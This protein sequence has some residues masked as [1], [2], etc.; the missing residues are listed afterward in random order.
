[1]LKRSLKVLLSFVVAFCTLSITSVK[2]E[3]TSYTIY[4]TPHD[5]SYNG[6]S[7]TLSDEMN[8]V[9]S[10]GIDKYTKSHVDDVLKILNKSGTEGQNVISNKTNVLVGIYGKDDAVNKYFNDNTNVNKDLFNKYDS[11]MLSIRDG[12]I[13]VLG[14]DTDAAFHGVTT[15]K[16]IFNQVKNNEIKELTINDYADVKGRGFIE[17]YYGNPWSNEDR[18]DL[19]TF[20]GD[21]KLNQYIYAPKDDPKHNS[22]WR[23][24]YT[25]K[26]LVEIAKLA[27]AGNKSKCY[28]VYAL[29]TFMHNAVRFDN[30]ENYQKDLQVIK[31]KF[32][33]LMGAGVKQ[34]AI[35]ADDA[36]VPAGGGASYTKLMKDLTDWLI[37]KQKTVEGLKSDTLFCPNDYMG[38]GTSG[39]MQALKDLPDSV[40]IIQTGGKVWGEVGPN[41]NDAFYNNMGRPAY[42]WIN[43]PCSDN[44]KDSL[45]MGGAEAVLKPNVDAHKVDGIV[46]NP[47][48][49]SEASKQGLFTNA[50]YAWNI[51]KDTDHYKTVWDDSFAFMDHGTIDETVASN[52]LR[53]MSKHMMNSKQIGNNESFDLSP[54]LTQFLKDLDAGVDISAQAEDL[55][56]EFQKLYD[57]A[58]NYK[59]NPG[60]ERTRNQ[61]VY[62]LDCWMDT[63]TAVINYLDTALALQNNA[64]NDVIWNYYAAGQTAFE[65]SKTHGFHYVD[66]TEYAVAGRL[67][68]NPFMKSLD[69]NLS[70]KME[71]II[72]PGKQIIKYISNRSDTPEGSTD[73]IFDNKGTTEIV[74]KNPNSIAEGTY[75]GISY[76]KGI[77]VDKVIFRLGANSNPKDTFLKAKV[78]YTHDGKEWKDLDSKIYDLPNEV[79]L[80]NLGLTGVK[81]IRMIATEAK[82]NTWLGVR[83]I[84]V[85]PVDEPIIDEDNGTISTDKISV[86]GGQLGNVNDGDAST[87]THFAES[88]YK[89]SGAPIT[90]YIPVDSKIIL[91]FEQT[92]QLGIISFKQDS[93]TD[94]IKKYAIEYSEDGSDWK[95]LKTYSSGDA[96]ISLDVSS[97]NIVA[98]AIRIR[99]L[100]LNLKNASVGYWWKVYDFSMQKAQNETHSTENVFTNTKF[101]L[102]TKYD[103]ALTILKANQDVTL[104]KNE[105]IGVDLSR[106]KDLKDINID[107][108]AN[109]QLTIQVS[110]NKVDWSTLTTRTLPDA[111]YVRLINLNDSEVTFKLNSFEVA[112]NE[113]VAPYLHETTMGINGSWGVGEDSRNNGAAFDGNVDTTTEFGDLP[114][115][116]QYIIYDLGQERSIK[117]LEMFCQDSAVNY[118]RDA[119]ILVSNDLK[120]WTKV[121]TIGDGIENT[122]DAGVKCIDSDAGYIAS[123]PY[124]NKVSVSGEIEATQARYIK[125]LMTA[126]NNNRAV[127]FNEI[128]INDGEYVPVSNDPTFDSSAIEVQGF[129]PQNMFDG[130]L[131]TSYKANTKD[132]GYIQYT[133]SDNLD[134][135]RINII[136]K[137]NISNAKVMAYVDTE[138]GRNWVQ[139]GA[140]DRSLNEIYLPFWKNIYELKIEWEAN[141]VPTISEIVMLS[142]DEFVVDRSKLKEY[143]D[144]LDIKESQYT[145]DT[146]KNYEETLRNANS[147]MADNNSSQNDI[148]KTLESLKVAV[149]SLD[150]RG[151]KSEISKEL[152]EIANLVEADYTADSWNALQEQIVLANTLLQKADNALSEKEV[153]VM[154]E[155]L[156]VAKSNLK[157]IVS[158][159][160]EILA[161]YIDDNELDKLDTSL[162]LTKTAEPFSEALKAAQAILLDDTAT[163][164]AIKDAHAILQQARADLI[165]KASATELKGLKAL[166]DVYD[167]NNYTKASWA[168]FKV[169]LDKVYKTI[170]ENESTSKDISQ[171]IDEVKAAARQLVERSNTAGL[172][173]LINLAKSLDKDKYTEESYNAVL[174]EVSSI[175]KL[176][177]NASEMSQKEID[178][179]QEQLQ[180]LLNELQ[181]KENNPDGDQGGNQDKPDDDQQKPDENRPTPPIINDGDQTTPPII[182]GGDENQNNDNNNQTNNNQVNNGQNNVAQT[183]DNT[184]IAMLLGFAMLSV[185]G[186]YVYRKKEDVK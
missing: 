58:K 140:L 159:N 175:E 65:Q 98:K 76:T 133:L 61:I 7:F 41:F 36:G 23:A 40:S 164:E 60:N 12:V 20:G 166:A 52:A 45:I 147:V 124:P 26:E 22:N 84:V 91:T 185:C 128:V 14:K 2:A 182:N 64:D 177:V 179:L 173:A 181:G 158:V 62:W 67:H 131:T 153:I 1:M 160:K 57:A 132:A 8:V 167:E 21:Y 103:E 88:P 72:N 168:E 27:E 38:W 101:D 16:H 43:W 25:E 117:K 119:D 104:K 169:V 86:Q 174:K 155:N 121:V 9:Y 134:V 157:T 137:G 79:V 37:E 46:L 100:E 116:G 28:Y 161:K 30:E 143:I 33:Q 17:G 66:H 29:H 89:P 110:K 139:V 178:D 92:K 56:L 106:I 183:G 102:E 55:K 13:A 96:D 19:M 156:N 126:T 90:D 113:V 130:D 75:V 80:E 93:G 44:T 83:D 87:F 109:N 95:E 129:A 82:P 138:S 35:L 176:L 54:K 47:M 150:K 105:F 122:D 69:N 81:G 15:L 142:G 53:E 74:Y 125:I 127:V 68:V 186:L 162:Y 5:V 18:A 97:Q 115:K 85:N 149:A 118:I 48:Q 34:F 170:D 99:N 152:D 39:Q 49:Q 107:T 136:Q 78:Q 112:S 114:Q 154:I 108:S 63:S 32:E 172:N 10:N 146:Y 42:M 135:D 50:D 120:N 51:W 180:T 165:L 4:P 151:N 171:L 184:N 145:V 24:L 141:K 59:A 73:S 77:D 148:N 163:V 31:T 71:T 123:S 11:Y 3:E 6:K 70:A 111:R 144:G 94:K